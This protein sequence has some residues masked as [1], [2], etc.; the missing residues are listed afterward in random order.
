MAPGSTFQPS[1][2]VTTARRLDPCEV[3]P[4]FWTTGR[5]CLDGLRGQFHGVALKA[6]QG[7][8]LPR[9]WW[10]RSWV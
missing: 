3:D 4:V 10:G 7:G 5:P 6:S 9:A 1:R 8:R 2:F